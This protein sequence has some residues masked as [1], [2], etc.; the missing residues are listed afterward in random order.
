MIKIFF[1]LF[2]L[3]F[4]CDKNDSQSCEDLGHEV[5]FCGICGGTCEENNPD[6]CEEVD[7]CGDCGGDGSSC[8]GCKIENETTYNLGTYDPSAIFQCEKILECCF[9]GLFE[10]IDLKF[11]TDDFCISKNLIDDCSTYSSESSCN[12]FSGD[13]EC[14]WTAT[15]YTY[16]TM[17][18]K[19]INTSTIDISIYTINSNPSYCD[20]SIE[21]QSNDCAL[22]E[23]QYA[24]NNAECNWI[25][26]ATFNSEWDQFE[27]II[28]AMTSNQVNVT[29]EFLNE[30]TE[31]YCTVIN[32]I[33][34]CGTIQVLSP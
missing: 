22:L 11:L 18:I 28:P 3:I 34:K 19:F 14:E 15:Y 21:N 4:S 16:K 17:P 13:K 10:P 26:S 7:E 23:N 30:T 12:D 24:C 5:D 31:T 25:E 32:N 9:Y 6:S 27:E 2:I 1:I 20:I 8:T 33:E 29:E